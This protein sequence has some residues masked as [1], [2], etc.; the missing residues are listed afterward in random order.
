MAP[1]S[2]R[3]AGTPVESATLTAT[4]PYTLTAGD[5]LF[6][7]AGWAANAGAP[8][9][10][11]N[12]TP[13]TPVGAQGDTGFAR[14]CQLFVIAGGA[15]GAHDAVGSF[16]V[17]A[18]GCVVYPFA[19]QNFDPGT[20][21]DNANL[22]GGNNTTANVSVNSQAGDRAFAVY[23]APEDKTISA[24]AGTIQDNQVTSNWRM[25]VIDDA[26]GASVTLEVTLSA[27]DTWLMDGLNINAPAST[28]LDDEDC[29]VVSQLLR[30]ARRMAEG[31][32]TV[33]A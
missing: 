6:V 23:L 10:T 21:T 9:V 30:R 13:M 11:W 8:T 28:A 32:V 22:G 25:A 7:L 16:A 33:Y 18:I 17:G 27:S 26:G 2:F 31:V 12:G 20:P 24:S 4:A 14:Y 29:G 3:S 15:S 5:L 1:P 19:Y